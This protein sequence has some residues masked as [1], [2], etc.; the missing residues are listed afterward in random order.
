MARKRGITRCKSFTAGARAYASSAANVSK[1]RVWITCPASQRRGSA[2]PVQARMANGRPTRRI[3]VAITAT[4]S[5]SRV[6]RGRVFEDIHLLLCH[7]YCCVFH[8]RSCSHVDTH[9]KVRLT[10]CSLPPLV[11]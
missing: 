5:T 7:G 1:S 9:K 4:E 11:L 3:H 10:V 2:T 6:A 8:D